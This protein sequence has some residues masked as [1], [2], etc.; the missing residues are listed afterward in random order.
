[1]VFYKLNGQMQAKAWT[2]LFLVL[3]GCLTL[4]L[5]SSHGGD[6]MGSSGGR[7]LLEDES[8]GS[9]KI[10]IQKLCIVK[11]C[12]GNIIDTCTKYCCATMKDQP[13]WPKQDDCIQYCQDY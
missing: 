4:T 7:R 8:V 2:P 12:A 11:S 10:N 1:M 13:C 9:D 6:R 3:F 5:V